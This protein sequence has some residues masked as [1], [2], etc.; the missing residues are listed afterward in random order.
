MSNIVALQPQGSVRDYTPTQMTLIKR[1]VAAD[2]NESEFDL[3]MEM[4]KRVGLDPFRKQIYAI[5]Y[6]KDKPAKRKMSIITGIDG[7]RAV[8]QRSGQ[9]RPDEEE[10]N[11]TYSEDLKGDANPLGIEK[12]SVT[13]HKYG[14]DKNWHPVK[15]VAY[16]DEFAPLKEGGE[17]KD[18]GQTWDDGNAK[19][20]FIPDGTAT[21]QAGNWV[22][23]PRVMIAKCA[24]AQAIRKGWPE[25]LSGV[26]A[27]EEMAQAE[28]ID[29]TP[30]QVVEQAAR[31]ERELLVHTKDSVA[32]QWTGGDPIEYVPLGQVAD[33]IMDFVRKSES[34]TELDWWARTNKMGLRDFW[35][36]SKGDALEVKLALEK[37][38][39]DLSIPVEQAEIHDNS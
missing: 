9:Y 13:V 38:T 27:P 29:I 12:A 26:Y 7:F 35:A 30:S 17:W 14:P 2:C 33:K 23:M 25:D 21:L 28:M 39:K 36:K 31:D 15:G 37:K 32:I 22:K 18:T 10:P 5:V 8:A 19:K 4:A 11:Y 20:T 24:E 34:A 1:T 3:Y 6:N 16:W